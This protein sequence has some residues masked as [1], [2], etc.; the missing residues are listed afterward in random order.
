MPI[1]KIGQ[2]N[3]E[4]LLLPNLIWT[5]QI[6]RTNNRVTVDRDGRGCV[7]SPAIGVDLGV[8]DQGIDETVYTTEA[9]V[10][11]IGE[12]TVFQQ[13]K[14]ALGDIGLECGCQ[15]VVVHIIVI[16][17]HTRHRNDQ[18]NVLI[19]PVA[20]IHSNRW[21]VDVC[22]YGD[23]YRYNIAVQQ[24]VVSLIGK[25]IHTSKRSIRCVGK[26]AIGCQSQG[27]ISDICDQNCSQTVF[28]DISVI[29][30]HT[31]GSDGCCRLEGCA[32]GI[33]YCH[34]RIVHSSHC[35]CD[36]CDIAVGYAIVG[37]VS[38]CVRAVEIKIRRIG[39]GSVRV[40]HQAAVGGASYRDRSQ[41]R[42]VKVSIIDEHT[43]CCDSQDAVFS[44]NVSII[45]SYRRNV[46]DFQPD[47]A[48]EG[49]A[50]QVSDRPIRY[51]KGE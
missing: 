29:S 18:L 22:R 47:A 4:S 28:I 34:R 20:V 13:Y 9:S 35:N 39:E 45:H 21:C 36:G 41:Y 43:A 14:C 31:R 44:H 33:V 25:C 24:A 15:I 5:G 12:G 49:I 26:G 17:Q 48:S 1:F 27:A 11:R 7:C 51:C 37:F 40:Q 23:G 16:V 8:T 10:G 38:E 2:R 19:C 42:R 30:E 32:I 46:Q 3:L 6:I 50:A